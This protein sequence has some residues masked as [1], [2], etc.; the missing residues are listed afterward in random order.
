MSTRRV[1][2]DNAA[3]SWPKPDSVYEAVDTYQRTNGCAFGRTTGVAADDV[4]RTITR[5]REQIRKLAGSLNSRVIHTFNGTDALNMAIHGVLNPGG[6]VVT[7]TA[8]HNSV[9]RPLRFLENQGRI[10]VTRVPCDQHGQV[11]PRQVIEQIRD[12]T[13]LV[14]VTHCSNVTGAINE[15]EPIGDALKDSRAL[16]LVDAAQSFGSIPVAMDQ[17]HIDLLAAPG[18]KS[19]L[20]PLGT[21]VLLVNEKSAKRLTPIRQGG[22]GVS[23]ESD[24]H[25]IDVPAGFESGNLNVPG[26]IGLQAGVEYIEHQSVTA[27]S[28]H[29]K[30]LVQHFLDSVSDV[31]PTDSA[32]ASNDARLVSDRNCPESG[33][34]S[35]TTGPYSPAEFASVLDS[36]FGIQCR[37]GFHCASL[38]HQALQTPDGCCRLSFGILNTLDD[39]DQAASAV[40]QIFSV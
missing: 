12:E 15:L 25:P 30:N 37:A 11:D 24:E 3:T 22:T 27:I 34:V 23:S 32:A 7:T 26:L 21:G 38:I 6:H 4:Q 39:V 40:R 1:Y 33:I 17:W 35:F 19:L 10:S 31:F 18:H 8:E 14:A 9:L 29:K 28:A 13:R 5:L 36:A 16:F 2:L 20:G